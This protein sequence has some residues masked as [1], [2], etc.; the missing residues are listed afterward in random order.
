[1]K[2]T[3]L[4]AILLAFREL[5]SV[6]RHRRSGMKHPYMPDEFVLIKTDETGS[7]FWGRS[8]KTGIISVF[9]LPLGAP[10]FFAA[11]SE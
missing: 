3:I 1:M 10:P 5:H 11:P 8:L 6:A 2:K 7:M 4:A 9:S